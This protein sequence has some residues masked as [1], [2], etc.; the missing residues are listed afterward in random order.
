M[1]WRGLNVRGA[2]WRESA[3]MHD[4]VHTR[5]RPPR[6]RVLVRRSLF[7]SRSGIGEKLSKFF[8]CYSSGNSCYSSISSSRSIDWYPYLPLDVTG[9]QI[10]RERRVVEDPDL[11]PSLGPSPHCDADGIEHPYV[12]YTYS[13]RSSLRNQPL[14]TQRWISAQF[15]SSS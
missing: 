11:G 6:T 3:A 7:Q 5:R 12:V 13:K 1:R 10:T 4:T 15:L 14:E 2:R 8:S 9:S